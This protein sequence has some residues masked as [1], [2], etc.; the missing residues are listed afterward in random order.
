M[1]EHFVKIKE[2]FPQLKEKVLLKNY[3][4]FRIGGEADF[5]LQISE[6]N[7]LQ[8]VLLM[9][10]EADIKYVVVGGGSNVLF[11]DDGFRGLVIVF[12][13]EFGKFNPRFEEGQV[14]LNASMLLSE[15]VMKVSNQGYSGFE[16]AVGIPGTVG[17]AIN[18]NAGAFG[19]CIADSIMKIDVLLLNSKGFEILSFEKED[20]CFNYRGSV[21]KNNCKYII[22]GAWFTVKQ[23]N[24]DLILKIIKENILKRN[25]KQP[26]S[27][28]I[29]SIFKNYEQLVD[30]KYYKK[31]PK[32]KD[33]NEKGL[34][35]AG[36]LIDM[37]NLK[38]MKIGDAQID[39]KNANF[40]INNGE[41]KA[42][43]VL[44]LVNIIKRAVNERFNILLEEEFIY[45]S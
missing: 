14:Y 36:Y 3:S 30:K 44:R 13:N 38:G 42:E 20:C 11:S 10:K 27:Y 35:P 18:G 32:L 16:W 15:A 41:A 21:F 26:N 1:Q 29:G 7:E 2:C 9:C 5:L 17:G 31:Y 6:V 43:N 37:C 4:T 19:G 25:S 28:S 8:K 34:I 12:K 24:K 33:F 40:I 45:I 22:T 39:L 23:D